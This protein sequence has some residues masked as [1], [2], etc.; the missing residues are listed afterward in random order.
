M[1]RRSPA[2]VRTVAAMLAVTLIGVLTG[3]LAVV[4]G[5][6]AAGAA[7]QCTQDWRTAPSAAYLTPNGEPTQPPR[8]LPPAPS[9]AHRPFHVHC[10]GR[11]VTTVWWDPER[12]TVPEA[13][14]IARDLV[15]TAV[16]PTVRP[17][18]NPARGITG[19]ASWFWAEADPEPVLMVAGNGPALD[20]ELRIVTVRWR[21][22]DGT[23]G[24]ISG[25]GAAHPAPSPVAHVFERKGSYPV[26]AQVVIGGW[27]WYEELWAP[28]PSGGHTVVLRHDVA[29]VRSLLHAR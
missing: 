2:L 4:D 18:V 10:G 15:A 8:T 24:A 23:P 26:T 28:V 13:T 17:A 20:L 19:L 7:V 5:T 16:I 11:Y 25:L 22:G 9:P 27:Y 12:V 3:G 1:E 6:R 29:E 14:R 21:F